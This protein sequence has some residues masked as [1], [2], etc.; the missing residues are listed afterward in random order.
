MLI[1]IGKAPSMGAQAHALLLNS[2]DP[3]T[4]MPSSKRD[5][6][7]I[8]RRLIASL[9]DACEAA[10]AEIVGFDWLTHEA[11]TKRFLKAGA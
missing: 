3:G 4:A 11:T 9:I 5:H 10:K 8:E 2:I 6:A 7:R 1:E